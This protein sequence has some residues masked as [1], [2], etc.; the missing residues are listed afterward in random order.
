ME[1]AAYDKWVAELRVDGV[2]VKQL[3]AK[4]WW[5]FTKRSREDWEQGLTAE[6]SEFY[7]HIQVTVED[8]SDSESWSEG[9]GSTEVGYEEEVC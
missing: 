6:E 4:P 1:K 7:S 2:P 8:S 9:K 3:P 5:P